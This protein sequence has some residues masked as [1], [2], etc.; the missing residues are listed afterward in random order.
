MKLAAM[1]DSAGPAESSGHLEVDL[2]T[3]DGNESDDSD[4]SLVDLEGNPIGGGYAATST[5]DANRTEN[6]HDPAHTAGWSGA[7]DAAQAPAVLA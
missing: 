2:R 4:A 6:K 1:E 5:S 7:T 3:Q